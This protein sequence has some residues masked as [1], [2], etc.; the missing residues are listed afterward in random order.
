M[1]RFA[2]SISLFSKQLKRSIKRRVNNFKIEFQLQI[3]ILKLL[4]LRLFEESS[5]SFDSVKS[6]GIH[7]EIESVDQSQ[8]GMPDTRANRITCL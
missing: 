5:E 7:S 2:E 1:K 3:L 6:G 8:V 4:I